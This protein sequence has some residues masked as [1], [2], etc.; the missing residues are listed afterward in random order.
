MNLKLTT[1]R[2]ISKT[3]L[4]LGLTLA[5]ISGVYSYFTSL[6]TEKN[7]TL[8]IGFLLVILSEAVRNSIISRLIEHPGNQAD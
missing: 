8:L 3:L 1:W 4:F 7:Y 2:K 6:P 5:L